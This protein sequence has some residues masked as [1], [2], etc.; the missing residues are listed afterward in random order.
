MAGEGKGQV[1]EPG[2]E[3]RFV[4]AYLAVIPRHEGKGVAERSKRSEAS[5]PERLELARERRGRGLAFPVW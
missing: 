5:E 4:V 2:E 1:I 3:Q